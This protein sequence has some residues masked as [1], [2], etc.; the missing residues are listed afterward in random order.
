[1][2]LRALCASLGDLP[3][4]IYKAHPFFS[5]ICEPLLPGCYRNPTIVAGN[6]SLELLRHQA[7][8]GPAGS[9]G[10]A[11]SRQWPRRAEIQTRPATAHALENHGRA[12]EED[13]QG[14]R[15]MRIL[16]CAAAA[17]SPTRGSCRRVQDRTAGDRDEK[18]LD[19]CVLD[20]ATVRIQGD[21]P[22]PIPPCGQSASRYCGLHITSSRSRCELASVGHSV[23]SPP[24]YRP[25]DLPKQ[26]L[27]GPLSTPP[28]MGVG[29][30]DKGTP[31][32]A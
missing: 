7:L 25:R 3:L 27:P 32:Q 4:L 19:A 29:Q 17:R 1:M 21:G 28:G 24:M 9:G 23:Y 10:L 31:P 13:A 20:S 15:E 14:R 5:F 12:Q 26:I 2:Q 16:R 30:A 11:G 18:E 22:A 6:R 8:P